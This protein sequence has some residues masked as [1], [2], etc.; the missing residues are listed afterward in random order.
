MSFWSP[1]ESF[2]RKCWSEI[3]ICRSF[4]RRSGVNY[5]LRSLDCI[6]EREWRKNQAVYYICAFNYYLWHERAASLMCIIEA[7]TLSTEMME[8]AIRTVSICDT[9]KHKRRQEIQIPHNKK[10]TAIFL[11]LLTHVHLSL[12]YR[13][14]AQPE[15]NRQP[16]KIR[17]EGHSCRLQLYRYKLQS[18]RTAY[19]R[20]VN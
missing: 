13:W 20:Q 19:C 16:K 3:N 7:H 5:T 6:A 14:C 1:E 2:Y 9:H 18:V 11:F 15:D 17:Q 8:D 12:R 10:K 4:A